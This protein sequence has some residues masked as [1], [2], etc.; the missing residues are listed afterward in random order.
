[1][2]SLKK[3]TRSIAFAGAFVVLGFALGTA[4]QQA[5]ADTLPEALSVQPVLSQQTTDD[6]T[7]T[8]LSEAE[9]SRVEIYERVAPSVVSIQVLRP[10]SSSIFITPNNNG[11]LPNTSSSGTGFVLDKEGHI[12]T[13]YHVVADATEVIIKLIDGTQVI[14]EIIGLDPHSDLA[15]IKI[16][17]PEDRLHPVTF[18]DVSKLKVGQDVITIG[19]PFSQDWTMTTGIISATNRSIQGLGSYSIGSAIQTDASI[20]PGNSGGPLLNMQGEVI[21]VTSQIQSSTRSNSGIGFAI[22]AVLAQ[23]VAQDLIETGSVAY[24]YI[25]ISGQDITLNVIRSRD[26]P[27]N[28]TGF[29]I[30]AIE[31]NSPALNSGLIPDRYNCSPHN[32]GD[33]ITSINGTEIRN[34]EALITYL[35]HHTRPGDVVTFGVQRGDETVEIEVTLGERPPTRSAVLPSVPSN[36]GE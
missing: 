7:E 28:Q 3:L 12:M 22:P 26:L 30:C 2:D 15:V 32:N 24:S 14:A 5:V 36:E 10:A 21:G 1:M 13:N 19:S 23:R 17:V 33:I 25:G 27:N 35:V 11:T 4:S 31:A 20:N 9:L 8:P 34:F 16:D 29:V 6:T 18:G